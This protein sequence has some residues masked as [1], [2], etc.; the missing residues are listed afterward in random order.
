M[1]KNLGNLEVTF[2]AQQNARILYAEWSK[3][4]SIYDATVRN[5]LRRP[6]LPH[7]PTGVPVFGSEMQSSLPVSTPSRRSPKLVA[8]DCRDFME[9]SPF[10]LIKNVPFEPVLPW[11]HRQ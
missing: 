10:E 3:E 1:N 7:R 11:Q 8:H 4:K 9:M 5:N 2:D 6:G